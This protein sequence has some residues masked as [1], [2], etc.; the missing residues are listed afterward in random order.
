MNNELSIVHPI[1]KSE[2]TIVDGFTIEFPRRRPN[3]WWRF[4]HKVFF[5]FLW[6]EIDDD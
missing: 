6:R 3:A 2:L 1:I 5:G 4:W